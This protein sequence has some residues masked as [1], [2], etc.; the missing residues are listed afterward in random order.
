MA[1][2]SGD[3]GRG[4]GRPVAER[5]A[6]PADPPEP[7]GRLGVRLELAEDR[8]ER[9]PL[10]PA[11]RRGLRVGRGRRQGRQ[12]RPGRARPGWRS[13]R[14]ATRRRGRSAGS[15]GRGSRGRRAP[16]PSEPVDRADPGGQGP[17]VGRERERAHRRREVDHRE[18]LVDRVRRGGGTS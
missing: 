15:G 4:V 1:A 5:A 17:A 2:S 9:R 8:Q 7:V 3:G 10:D 14:P 13:T 12:D 11:C 18:L 6:H 16:G